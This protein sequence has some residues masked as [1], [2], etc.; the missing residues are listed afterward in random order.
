MEKLAANQRKWTQIN[1][2]GLSDCLMDNALI[3]LSVRLD[4]NS[5]EIKQNQGVGF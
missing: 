2:L 5:F 3:E 1:T 4:F